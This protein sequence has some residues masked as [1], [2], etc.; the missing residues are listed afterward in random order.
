LEVN[1]S[2]GQTDYLEGVP[3]PKNRR[4]SNVVLDPMWLNASI[5]SHPYYANSTTAVQSWLEPDSLCDELLS[6][7][8]NFANN[9]ITYNNTWPFSGPNSNSFTHS[10]LNA[11]G[12]SVE[13]GLSNFWFPGWSNTSVPFGQ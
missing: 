13:G 5:G 12:L 10:L 4:R 8:A 2:D 7:V 9:T 6:L 3:I 1:F 11:A